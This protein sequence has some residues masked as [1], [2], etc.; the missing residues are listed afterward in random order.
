MSRKI[1]TSEQFI[2]FYKKKAENLL[3]LVDN[4]YLNKEYRKC[5]ELLNQAYSMYQKGHYMEEAEKVKQRFNEIKETHFK[6][7]E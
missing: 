2:E 6:K 4:H 5:L 1:D 7:K 3:T